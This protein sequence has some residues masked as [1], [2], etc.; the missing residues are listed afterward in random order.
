MSNIF[1]IYFFYFASP[2]DH[3]IMGLQQKLVF[4]R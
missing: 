3:G 1:E 2:I 4:G